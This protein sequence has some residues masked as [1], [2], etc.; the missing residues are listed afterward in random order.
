MLTD[1][2]DLV[3]DPFAGSCITGEASERM[4]RRWKCCE[5]V[6][7]YLHGA[8]GRFQPKLHRYLEVKSGREREESYRI[9]RPG[10][11]QNG[12]ER[13]KLPRDGGKKRPAKH[14]RAISEKGPK[15]ASAVQLRLLDE[16]SE[17]A[18]NRRSRY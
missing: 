18:R 14:E 1:V 2:D 17:R 9:F 7:E 6:E 4:Q 8:L 12:L 13:E 15:S 16:D 10:L 11:I 3:I 5:I